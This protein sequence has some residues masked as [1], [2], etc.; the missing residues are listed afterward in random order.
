[1]GIK[2]EKRLDAPHVEVKDTD[3][4]AQFVK[5]STET[6][7]T[8]LPEEEEKKSEEQLPSEEDV[9]PAAKPRKKGGRPKKAKG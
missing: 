4:G 1:M 9:Q 2:Q 7:V 5:A 8:P 3:Y 6:K